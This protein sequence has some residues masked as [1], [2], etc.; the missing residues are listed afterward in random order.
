MMKTK[1]KRIKK[2][3]RVH[4]L[5]HLII[6]VVVLMLF[7]VLIT[8]YAE[9]FLSLLLQNH[10]ESSF[11]GADALA[12]RIESAVGDADEITEDMLPRS[13]KDYGLFDTEA[14]EF[15]LLPTNPI[16]TENL[17]EYGFNVGTVYFD[18]YG[19]ANSE[20]IEDDI[21]N[22]W[23]F[24]WEFINADYK[25]F[26]NNMH[27]DDDAVT[28]FNGWILKSV[29]NDKYVLYY[30]TEM[31]IYVSDI[32]YFSV[33]GISLVILVGIPLILYVSMLISTIA[34]QRKAARILYYDA[35]TGGKNWLFFTERA[36]KFIKNAVRGKRK[37]AMV[38]LRMERYQS[39]C[40]CYGPVEG[41]MVVE[42][43]KEIL[44]QAVLKRKE[45]FARYA[46]AEFGLMLIEENP[47]QITER[48]E[49]IRKMLVE[50]I[51]E[52]KVDFNMGIC[53]VTDRITPD[54]LYSNASLARKNVQEKATEKI[55]RFNEKL[56]EEQV[57]EHFME[58]NMEH[59]LEAGELHVYL[60]PKYN[61]K[62]HKLGGAEALIRWISP[63]KGFIGPG[64]F[65]PIFEKNGFITKIDDFM[66]KSVA[67]LQAKWVAEGR[68]VVPVSVN[69]SRA[70]FTRDDLAE[71]I[72]AIVDAA[73]APKNLIEL[74][75][76][77]SAFFE[78]KDT[79]INTVEKLKKMGFAVSMDDFGAGYSSLNSLKD[80]HLDVLKI[81]ADFFRGREENE[82]RSSLI[83]SE[84]IHL[85][86]NLGMTTVAEG[87]ESAEQVE[88]LAESGCDLI[89][90]FYFAK[91][92]P[93]EEYIQKM[94]EDK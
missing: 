8:A 24:G 1:E 86:Q 40:A 17:M 50:G 87:I 13:L 66:L 94:E 68:N 93:V 14:G 29:L 52:R 75:L 78:D 59:A 18:E 21:M 2:L 4:L 67:E 51:R 92:M 38:S 73:G 11:Q 61:A 57:W 74:E 3:K 71:H 83:V 39:F 69:I 47:E 26:F 48:V 79:L 32:R 20:W 9:L 33:F 89:Q 44:E 43:I 84:T 56:K 80:L 6:L 65:I 45:A 85:A 49:G 5:P 58:E 90:G 55:F 10:L 91:P 12:E 62:T 37:Y 46:E 19:M 53:E 76:T 31:T 41:E 77:E 88:F 54:E 30:S 7:T 27:N 25:T 63:T 72:C 70:H 34:S 23:V 35:V 15:I 64:R 36:E 82:E 16:D 22:P 42:Q 60:Q 81:D 28:S